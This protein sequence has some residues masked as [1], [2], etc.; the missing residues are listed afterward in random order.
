MRGRKKLA[1]VDRYKYSG[2]SAVLALRVGCLACLGT[3]PGG[4]SRRL[5]CLECGQQCSS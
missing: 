5:A 3:R 1:K 4:A 2:L